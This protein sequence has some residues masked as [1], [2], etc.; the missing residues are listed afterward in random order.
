LDKKKNISIGFRRW[1]T[2][3][4]VKRTTRDQLSIRHKK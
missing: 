4:L 3:V 1:E 2:F